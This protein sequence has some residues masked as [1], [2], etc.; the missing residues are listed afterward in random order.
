MDRHATGWTAYA[1]LMLALLAVAI[2]M[3]TRAAA[4]G[5]AVVVTSKPVHALVAGVMQ[6]VGQP[7]LLVDGAASPHSFTLRPSQARAVQG[8]D[9]FVRVGE[10]VEPFTAA[11]IR[12]L[13][14]RVRV[15]T[16][17]EAAGVHTLPVRRSAR[18]AAVGGDRDDHGGAHHDHDHDAHEHGG[19]DGHIWLDPENAKAIV[20]AIAAVLAERDPDHAARYSANA[21]AIGQRIGRLSR[22]LTEE[23]QPVRAKPFVVFHDATQYFERRFGLEAVGAIQIA[24]N[25]PPSARRL[26][27]VRAAIRDMHAECVLAEPMQQSH[28]IDTVVEGTAA[29]VAVIDPEAIRLDPGPELYFT[30]MW[31]LSGAIAGCL[32]REQRDLIEMR[33]RPQ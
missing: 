21:E 26:S 25:V 23:L 33:L 9:I 14:P 28:I 6:G 7:E 11:L 12:N 10:T 2:G 32:G 15:V 18:F 31:N 20:A 3:P 27:E 24:P 30:L 29:H 5:P 16:L 4:E 22:L 13:P 1:A 8:A 19:V 17:A